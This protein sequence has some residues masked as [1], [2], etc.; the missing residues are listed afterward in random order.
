M[1]TDLFHDTNFKSGISNLW[2]AGHI[3]PSRTICVA[4]LK[5]SLPF[6]I[7]LEEVQSQLLM[8]LIDLQCLKDLKNKFLT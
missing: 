4:L 3:Q 8:E 6:N 2:L 5:L 1:V 7:K